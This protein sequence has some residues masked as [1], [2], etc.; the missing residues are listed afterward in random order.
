M[1]SFLHWFST[2]PPG[3]LAFHHKK[4]PPQIREIPSAEGIFI[5]CRHSA[6]RFFKITRCAV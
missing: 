3:I 6:E 1:L 4:Y 5:F 2:V